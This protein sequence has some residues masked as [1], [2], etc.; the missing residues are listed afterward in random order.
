MGLIEKW[1]NLAK[2]KIDINDTI[3]VSVGR[4][5]FVSVITIVQIISMLLADTPLPSLWILFGNYLL[6][7]QKKSKENE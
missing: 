1:N 7:L 3:T 6:A 5:V 4:L 2:K